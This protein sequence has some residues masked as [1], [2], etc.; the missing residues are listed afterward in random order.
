VPTP[1]PQNPSGETINRGPVC[2]RSQNILCTRHVLHSQII[3]RHHIDQH[4]H[5]DDTQL[6]CSDTVENLPSLLTNM[7]YCLQDIKSWMAQNKLQLDADKTEAMLI[8]TEHKL[9]SITT[10]S[11][12]FGN[13]SVP[14]SNSV[15][16]LG[17][18][19]D[20]TLSMKK[21]ITQTCQSCYYHLRRI[22]AICK[23]LST[24]ATSIVSHL[25]SF[26]FRLL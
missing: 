24:D 22:S 19:L 14:L 21:F 6:Q 20:N 15:K 12:E 13:T 10:S 16:Y 17:V 26:T 3:D 9:S 11:I 7:S 5:A 4:F 8:G 1:L 25:F 23:Y 2:Q 18:V